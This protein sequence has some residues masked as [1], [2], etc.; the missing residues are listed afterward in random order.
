MRVSIQYFVENTK[1]ILDRRIDTWEALYMRAS[2]QYQCRSVV[3]KLDKKQPSDTHFRWSDSC[4]NYTSSNSIPICMLGSSSSSVMPVISFKFPAII[5]ASFLLNV[6]RL[7]DMSFFSPTSIRLRT[8]FCLRFPF[9]SGWY[10]LRP[11]ARTS[12]AIFHTSDDVSGVVWVD[13]S[14]IA[15][16]ALVTCF[17]TFCSWTTAPEISPS[18]SQVEQTPLETKN[19]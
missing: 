2:V 10:S 3:S 15:P 4:C 17:L 11:S 19:V 5:Q 1:N 14:Y 12:F 16:R 13:P 7:E 9:R 8:S 6:A 18:R